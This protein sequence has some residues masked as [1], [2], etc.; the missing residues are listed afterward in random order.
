MNYTGCRP[1]SDDEIERILS[2][3]HGRYASR[4]RLLILLGVYTGFRI[5]EILSLCISDVWDGTHARSSVRVAAGF[6]KGKRYSRVMPLH[7]RVRGAIKAWLWENGQMT[8]S[9]DDPP[10]FPSQQ[11]SRALSR[12]QVVDILIGAAERAGIDS[13]RIATHSLR[14]SFA[15]RM[16]E[17]PL[18]ERDPAKMARLLG[19]SNWSNTLR[20][21]EFANELEAAVLA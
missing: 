21:L 12:R 14:K 3:C 6:M 18:V 5:S 2:E 7:A 11:T 15:R 19:H 9:Y 20:Y 1:L 4:D 13:D 10:L 17:S 16:W 8:L